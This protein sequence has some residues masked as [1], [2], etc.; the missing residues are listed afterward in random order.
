MA[1]P[2]G[3]RPGPPAGWR[4]KVVVCDVDGTV[5]FKDRRLDPLALEAL[6][7]VEA[8][9]I[10]VVLATGNVLPIAYALSYMIGTTGP[11]V[12]ENGGLLYHKGEVRELSSRD[13]VEAVA[14]SVEQK[15]GLTRLFTDQWRRTE[16]AFPE[17]E[18][19]FEAVR[20]EVARHPQG[21]RVRVERTGFA[22][23]LMDPSAEKFKG[24][25]AAL[26]IM[27]LAPADALACGDA[28]NDTEMVRRCGAGVA[29]A[30]APPGLR[31]VATLVTRGVAG[32]GLKEA[33]ARYGA[34]RVRGAARGARG[35]STGARRP[36]RRSGARTTRAAPAR[37]PTRRGRAGRRAGRR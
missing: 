10:P 13:D 19:T 2:A 35:C 25:L 8:A 12:A 29:L 15:M 23:H 4:P 17:K 24:V 33:F 27:G 9:G 1:G 31:A 26:E 32:R 34:T 11:I 21:A 16:V 20:I 30:D 18:G 14:R 7:A 5:T 36:R 6:R 28:D 37:P 22:V 3:G